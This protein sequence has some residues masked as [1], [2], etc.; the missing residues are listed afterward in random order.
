MHAAA[1]LRGICVLWGVCCLPLYTGGHLATCCTHYNR[2]AAAT[3]SKTTRNLI[4]TGAWDFQLSSLG[5]EAFIGW[6]GETYLPPA[7][8]PPAATAAEAVTPVPLTVKPPQDAD[9]ALLD[10]VSAPGQRLLV[11]TCWL[12]WTIGEKPH[13]LTN[14]RQNMNSSIGASGSDLHITWL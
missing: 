14:A 3:P 10:Q 8:S 4:L 12:A 13:Q 6:R 1:I 5:Q 9:I 2:E 11:A 7:Q